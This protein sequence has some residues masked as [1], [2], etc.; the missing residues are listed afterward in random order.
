M[1]RMRS[2][3]GG[4]SSAHVGV[5]APRRRDVGCLG[6]AAAAQPAATSAAFSF[7]RPDGVERIG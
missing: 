4:I 5:A 2:S 6:V 7:A 3:P 1:P